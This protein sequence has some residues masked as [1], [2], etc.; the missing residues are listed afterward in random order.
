MPAIPT[1]LPGKGLH[2]LDLKIVPTYLPSSMLFYQFLLFFEN[3]IELNS[4]PKC[5]QK[6]DET[7]YIVMRF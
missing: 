5:D 4:S 7:H 1:Y 3:L 2:I 6:T